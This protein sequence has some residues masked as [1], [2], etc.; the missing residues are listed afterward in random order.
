MKINYWLLK[1]EPSTW[2]WEDQAKA[3]VEMWDGVRNYQ[4]RNNLM[5]MKKKD[6]C[7]FYHSVSEKLIIGIVEVVKEHYPDPTDKTGRFVVTDVKAKKKLKN[8][9]SLEEIKA[10]PK[11]SSIAL[12]KQSRLSVMPLS[13][14][15]WEIILEISQK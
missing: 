6:L 15:E 7:F 5:K 4:A 2:S 14:N 3:G 9:V 8:P 12:I 13:K 11:L 1:S 10:N